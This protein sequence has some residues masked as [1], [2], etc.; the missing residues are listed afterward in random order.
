MFCKI[1][2]MT[3]KIYLYIVMIVTAIYFGA[4]CEQRSIDTESLPASDVKV[5]VSDNDYAFTSPTSS[6]VLTYTTSTLADEKEGYSYD[7]EYPLFQGG[8]PEARER[9]NSAIENYVQENIS[10]FVEDY[11]TV[12]HE[13]DPGPWFLSI[14]YSVSRNDSA[15][16][17]VL[18]QG[19]V[20]TGGAHPNSFF[21]SYLFNLEES[22]RMMEVDDVFNP[23]ASGINPKTGLRQNYLQYISSEAV[24]E[25]LMRDISDEGW[26]LDGA[27]PEKANYDTFY[28]TDEEMVFVFGAYQVAPYAAG[29]QEI[30]FSYDELAQYLKAYA[31]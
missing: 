5:G 9:I 16:V 1:N 23:M 19:S 11:E 10:E 6:L 27:G 14:D 29:P 18:I 22:G 7:L 20:Y 17:S 31:F 3:D 30:G 8:E 28:L 25:L 4:G 12:D 26:L 24:S 15:F 2:F 13:Y 21:K